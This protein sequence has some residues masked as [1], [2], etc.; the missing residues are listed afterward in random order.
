[1]ETIKTYQFNNVE[2]NLGK[3]ASGDYCV[4]V[5]ENGAENRYNCGSLEKAYEFILSYAEVE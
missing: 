4:D 2:F 3:T 5:Y 1:M